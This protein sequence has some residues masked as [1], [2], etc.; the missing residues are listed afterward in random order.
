MVRLILCGAVAFTTARVAICQDG[1]DPRYGTGYDSG[2]D[3]SAA[4][5]GNYGYGYGAYRGGHASTAEEGM[6]R[7]MA[8][9]IRSRAQASVSYSQAAT[10]A[11]RAR[12]AY[13]E[14]RNFAISSFV[15]NR[16]IRDE[17][18]RKQSE[19]KKEKL[20]AY[21]KSREYQPLTSSDFY[22]PTGKISWPLGLMHPHD[23]K[24]RKEIEELF[25]KRA[26]DGT[27]SAEEYIRLNKLLNMWVYHVEDH[28]SDF[29]ASEI[30]RSV[31]FLRRL[32]KMLKED[33]Q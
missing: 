10:E 32:E 16:A 9:V 27:L 19:A 8:D 13:L 30:T 1:T 4:P 3:Y 15:E 28:A 24:G 12:R 5:V 31:R 17:F 11:E 22:E 29:S 21:I 6:A 33:Y 26:K 2:Y 23:E 25:A 14:N 20:A 18:R 7:G